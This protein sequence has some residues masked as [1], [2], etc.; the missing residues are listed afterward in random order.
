[1]DELHTHHITHLDRHGNVQERMIHRTNVF[2][3]CM[4]R[5][6]D[7]RE[8]INDERCGPLE[9]AD[10]HEFEDCDNGNP[11]LPKKQHR[12]SSKAKQ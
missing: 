6:P 2:C 8:L 9:F 12:N 1:M 4:C 7:S 10:A 3:D 11:K 5:F